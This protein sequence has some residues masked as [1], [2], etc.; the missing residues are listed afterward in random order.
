M[1]REFFGAVLLCVAGVGIMTAQSATNTLTP[2]EQAEG[3][4]LLFDGTSLKGWRAFKS[5]TPPAGW[6]AVKGELVREGSGGDLLTADQFGDFEL[7]LEW[8]VTKNGNSGI[9]FRVTD[10]A[11]LTY[12]T[13]PEFQILD[14]GGHKDGAN[15]LTSAGSN[16]AMHAPVRDVT[17]PV[18]EWN[19]VRLIVRGAHVAHWM[20]GVTVL[21]YDGWGDGWG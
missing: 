7:R 16:Y 11:N 3:W 9:M 1:T 20:Y 13:G 8:K 12:E 19:D 4:K 17:R 21:V 5:E 18:G 15:P 2:A 14:N 6:K 10:Q